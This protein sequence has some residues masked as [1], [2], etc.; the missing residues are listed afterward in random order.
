MHHHTIS[1]RSPPG[2]TDLASVMPAPAGSVLEVNTLI[3]SALMSGRVDWVRLNSA[4]C[5]L[6]LSAS[7]KP[8]SLMPSRMAALI[9]RYVIQ[10]PTIVMS[11]DT[12]TMKT[13]CR[14]ISASSTWKFIRFPMLVSNRNAPAEGFSA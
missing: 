8:D 4:V 12:A 14:A 10:S 11:S 13:I 5:G 1:F 6:Y 3:Q 9:T 2:H 7:T